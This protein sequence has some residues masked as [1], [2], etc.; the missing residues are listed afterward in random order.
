MELIILKII[1]KVK[2]F[3]IH[4]LTG[5][6]L[7]TIHVNKFQWKIEKYTLPWYTNLCIYF[8]VSFLACN[9]DFVIDINILYVQITD[10]LFR[11]NRPFGTDLRAIDIQRGRDHGL[12]SYNDF[13][14]FCGLPRAKNFHDFG[15]YIS[16]EVT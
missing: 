14:Q 7:L 5:S 3:N 11:N 10:Y 2:I 1:R 4:L 15:D 6:N 9:L 13:R 12:A 8:K 16:A